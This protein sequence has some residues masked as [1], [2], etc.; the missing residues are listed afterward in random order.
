M[1]YPFNQNWGI[2]STNPIPVPIVCQDFLSCSLLVFYVILKILTWLSGALAVIMFMW[3]GIILI[4]DYQKAK[5]VKDRLIWGILGLVLA[6][7]AW[8]LVKFIE[9]NISHGTLTFF[10]NIAY[11][12][13]LS[14]TPPRISCARIN[15]FDVL[16]GESIPPGLLGR[17]L[18]W[19][20]MKIL[21]VIYTVS[22]L[23]AIGFII[24]GGMKLYMKPG[25]QAGMNYIIWAIIGAIVTISAYSIVKAIEY[26]LTH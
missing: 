12:Q 18:L 8:G 15:I 9:F 6:L 14:F 3:A 17:C 23:G 4:T 24:Y 22:M 21:A 16:S 2:F 5:E 26:S 25:D 11:A 13:S 20:A 10:N 1:P 7:I 19:L